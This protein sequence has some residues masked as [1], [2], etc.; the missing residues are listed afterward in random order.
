MFVPLVD[1]K[2]QFQ[3][4]KAEINAAISGVFEQSNFILGDNVKKFENEFCQY[5]GDGRAVSVHSGTDALYLSL[6]ACGISSGDEVITVA[7]TFIATYLAVVQTGA[8]PVFVDIDSATFTIDPEKIEEKITDKT[9]AIIPVHLYGHPAEMDQISELARKHN[10]FV[11][12]DACQAHGAEVNG[13]KAGLIGDMG[14]FSFYPTK[15]LGGY[16][17]GGLVVTKNDDFFDKLRLLRNYGQKKKY[18]HD[19]FGINSRLDEIQ[20]AIL[21]VKLKHLDQWINL[22][23]KIA[24]RYCDKIKSPYVSCPIEMDGYSHVYHLFVIKASCRD[25]LQEWLE[26]RNIQTQIHYPVP[27]HMQKCF[28]SE[29]GINLNIP[30]TERI[31]NEILSLPMY[32][33]MDN[34]QIEHTIDSINAFRT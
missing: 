12:E 13:R 24:K 32:P 30:Q 5:L 19:G 31:C 25:R 21:R 22:R 14:C 33:E 9:K 23:R 17:D 2:I 1:L 27:I 15:N 28:M 34:D 3:K 26:S 20:A 10:L 6:L 29:F 18:Y 4:L 11:I 7:H 16:G 8:T